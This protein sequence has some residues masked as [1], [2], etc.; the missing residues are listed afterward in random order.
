MFSFFKKKC[1]A[2]DLVILRCS[3]RK[4]RISARV[5]SFI[6]QLQN[7]A[8]I[9]GVLQRWPVSFRKLSWW[10][11]GFEQFDT[12]KWLLLFSLLILKL[13]PLGLMGASSH[14]IL[15]T[16]DVTPVFG[17]IF[18]FCE[19]KMFQAHLVRFL[20]SWVRHFSKRG[21]LVLAGHSSVG[22]RV[23]GMLLANGPVDVFRPLQWSG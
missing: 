15:S 22:N 18:A 11:H 19:D 10:A 16:C 17:S 2:N 23:V 6:Y 20:S 3:Y 12:S 5:L 9:S 7:N 1:L 8:T 13:F 21:C 14:Q 4:G